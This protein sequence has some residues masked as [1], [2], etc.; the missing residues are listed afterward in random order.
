[1]A[2]SPC[3]LS[4]SPYGNELQYGVI[5]IAVTDAPFPYDY[6]S[7]ANV[8]ITKVEARKKGSTGESTYEMLFQGE[9]TYNLMELSN[10]VT[11]TLVEAEVPVASYDLIRLYISEGSVVLTNGSSFDLTVPSGGAT[12]I[13]LFVK[14]DIVVTGGVSTDLLLD[15]DISRSFVATGNTNAVDGITGFIFKPVIKAANM[16][17][18]GTLTGTVTELM[19]GTATDLEGVQIGV[20]VAD[21]LNTTAFTDASGAYTILGLDPGTYRVTAEKM[22]YTAQT[23]DDVEIVVG[24]ATTQDFELLKE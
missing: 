15:F 7:E 11:K 1:M 9:T 18:A 21:T 2:L 14:P 17:F 8:T 22:G 12:G 4:C 10:G 24:N 19:D 16:S 5:S 23:V 13:K 6:V 3:L 20:I